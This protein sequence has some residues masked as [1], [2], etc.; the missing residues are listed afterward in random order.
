[1]NEQTSEAGARVRE[2]VTSTGALGR[3]AILDAAGPT[4]RAEESLGACVHRRVPGKLLHSRRH[5][6]AGL[7]F[8]AAQ[9][10]SQWVQPS[11]TRDGQHGHTHLH[12][13]ILEKS[14][15][16][17][18]LHPKLTA[19]PPNSTLLV[20][21]L[22]Q[23]Q[24][25]RRR[26]VWSQKRCYLLGYERRTLGPEAQ[27]FLRRGESQEGG[28]VCGRWGGQHGSWFLRDGRHR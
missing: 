23:L 17:A 6:A 16:A 5:K 1:M 8:L 25:P 10:C 4:G 12:V 24:Q 28:D 22:W 3:M 14:H 15:L 2:H 19:S 21:L 7:P 9:A 26:Q 20:P 13:Y 11:A 27:Q 18:P